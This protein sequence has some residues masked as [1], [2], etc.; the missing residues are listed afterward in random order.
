Y[1][2]GIVRDGAFER[3]QLR[4]DAERR[5]AQD[6]RDGVDIGLGDRGTGEGDVADGFHGKSFSASGSMMR[7]CALP[8]SRWSERSVWCAA[9]GAVRRYPAMRSATGACPAKDRRSP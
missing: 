2:A 5:G 9:R 3:V 7:S 8:W 1:G 4:S 6:G